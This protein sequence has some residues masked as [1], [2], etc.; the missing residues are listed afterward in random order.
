MSSPLKIGL[1]TIQY[2]A[3]LIKDVCAGFKTKV[4]PCVFE[5]WHFHEYDAPAAPD[6]IMLLAARLW[7]HRGIKR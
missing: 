4:P 3:P 5:I 2:R 1:R 6:N 7:C